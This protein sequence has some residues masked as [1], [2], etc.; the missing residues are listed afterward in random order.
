MRQWFILWNGG[1]YPSYGFLGVN[2]VQINRVCRE[3]V[4]LLKQDSNVMAN[5]SFWKIS[6]IL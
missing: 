4:R 3:L 6:S 1:R 2:A 5:I